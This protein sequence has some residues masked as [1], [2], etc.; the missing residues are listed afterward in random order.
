[1]EVIL[2]LQGKEQLTVTLL[3]W[4]WWDER[5]KRREEGRSRS[6]SE[7]AYMAAPYA[8]NFLKTPQREL[9]SENRQRPRWKKPA[10]G[11]LKL[12]SDGAFREGS[13]DDG[14]GFVIR[15]HQGRVIRA[16]AG[17]EEFLLNAFHAEFLGCAAGSLQEAARMGI[18]R[19]DIETDASLV[20]AALASNDYR[21]SEVGGIITEM[22]LLLATDFSSCNISICNRVCNGVA[23][24][25]AALG[26]N[27]PSGQ[28]AIWEG[29]P[30]EVED[31]MTSDLAGMN[32]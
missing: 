1:M 26:Y 7:I 14:W 20:K 18:S 4:T 9:L 23:H 2:G 10:E 28:I 17:R 6:P 21:L 3:L 5:N 19:L 32:E 8:A 13:K 12:N 29:A 31:M 11:I 25:L 30:H 22:K 15:N 24:S 27:F 16:G